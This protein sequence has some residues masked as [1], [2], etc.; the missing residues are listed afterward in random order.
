[1]RPWALGRKNWLQIGSVS[2]GPKVAAIASY[3]PTPPHSE[4]VSRAHQQN[5]GEYWRQRIAQQKAS[6][7][8]VRAFWEEHQL[9]EQS[10][11]G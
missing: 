7:Q 6:G 4:G 1:M 2:A 10:F 11:Y 3:L 8:T 9:C 5:R